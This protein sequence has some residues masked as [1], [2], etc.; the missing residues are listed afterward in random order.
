MG[1]NG[2]AHRERRRTRSDRASKRGDAGGA[3]RPRRYPRLHGLARFRGVRKRTDRI[4]RERVSRR[5]PR[6]EPDQ[7][8]AIFHLERGEELLAERDV[9]L[10]SAGL[11]KM[12]PS[13]ERAED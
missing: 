2:A 11:G 3:R 9:T 1:G 13:G 10:L 5:G 8:V 7:G 12:C 4:A 6:H